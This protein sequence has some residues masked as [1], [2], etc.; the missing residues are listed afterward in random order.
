M[1]YQIL[2]E[3]QYIEI[4]LNNMKLVLKKK[5]GKLRVCYIMGSLY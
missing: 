2:Y 5:F 3:I 4:F 1:L